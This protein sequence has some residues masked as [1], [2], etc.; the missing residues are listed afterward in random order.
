MTTPDV[1]ADGW[2]PGQYQK[3]AS[4]RAQPFQDLLSLVQSMP[5]GRVIDL[6]CGTGELTAQLHAHTQ[7][8]TTLGVD[9]SQAMLERAA[10]HAT[11][12]LRFVVGD[13]GRFET[14]NRFDL[15]FANAALHWVPDHPALLGRLSRG[16]TPGGQLAVQVPANLDHPSHTVAAEVANEEP[17]RQ[18]MRGVPPDDVV[19]H[20]LA[21]ERYAEELDE[22]GFVDQHVRLQVYGHHLSST[23]EVVEWTK[24]T[25]LVRFRRLLPPD[26]FEAFVAHYRHR[27]RQVLGMRSPY[28]YAFKRI[29]FWG[30]GP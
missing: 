18:A 4:E 17:Y 3:F 2:D 20:V 27:L 1:T 5:G 9:N 10:T 26:L 23:D 28:F 16:L 30:R 14:E 24:G 7:A 19:R 22:L 29:L 11:G 25:S 21:P 6:G 8:A 13:I 12:R 15:I